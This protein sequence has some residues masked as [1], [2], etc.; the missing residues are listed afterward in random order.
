MKLPEYIENAVNRN[1]YQPRADRM[2]VTRLIGPP[3]IRTLEIEHWDKIEEDAESK[4]WALDGIGFD[5]IMKQYSR[6]GLTNIKLEVPLKGFTVVAKLDYY[7]VLTHVLADLKRTSIWSVK[8]ALK[9][10]KHDWLKQVNVYDRLF[11]HVAPQLPVDRLEIHAFARDWRPVEK[12]RY[13]DYPKKM[14][15]IEV[16]RWSREEQMDYID[17]Q[18]QD[19]IKNPKR[20]CT[21]EEKWR[22]SDQY[23][24]M[25]VGRKSALKVEDSEQELLTWCKSKGHVI[26]EKGISVVKR[27]GSCVRCVNY[28]ALKPFCP[29]MKNV[30]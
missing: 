2:S 8:D 10:C 23:A 4:L 5:H 3:L 17:A 20:E 25:K 6:W 15:V 18:L 14:E 24:A 28:C 19:H 27:P 30:K 26:G 1:E 13:D 9:N 12:L 11:Y 16:P 29:H 22:K 21:D 7:N